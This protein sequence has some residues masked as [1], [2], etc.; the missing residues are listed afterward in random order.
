MPSDLEF[1]VDVDRET[2]RRISVRQIDGGRFLMVIRLQFDKGW[3]SDSQSVTLKDKLALARR[4]IDEGVPE[5]AVYDDLK[6]EAPP[7]RSVLVVITISLAIWLV[8]GLGVLRALDW[9]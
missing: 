9:V 8:A 4:L 3:E 7:S 1:F 6:M 5:H 2:I